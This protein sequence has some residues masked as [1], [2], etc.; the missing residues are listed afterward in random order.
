M[1]YWALLRRCC[2]NSISLAHSPTG[3]AEEKARAFVSTAST[4][5]EPGKEINI[6]MS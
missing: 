6:L 5:L 2:L 1:C 4:E 3:T